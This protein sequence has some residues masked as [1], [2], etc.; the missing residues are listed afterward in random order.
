M[1]LGKL[2]SFSN[3]S[4]FWKFRNRFWYQLR[5]P[6]RGAGG[7]PFLPFFENKKKCPDFAKK[8]PDYAHP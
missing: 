6:T 5:R 3:F 4:N 8:G 1:I 2:F 7:R